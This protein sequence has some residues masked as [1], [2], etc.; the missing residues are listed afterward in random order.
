M[1][2]LGLKVYAFRGMK[3]FSEVSVLD[4]KMSLQESVLQVLAVEF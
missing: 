3:Q 1:Y 2:M 4:S